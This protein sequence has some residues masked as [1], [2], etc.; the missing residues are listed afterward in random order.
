MKT[1]KIINVKISDKIQKILD[2]ISVQERTHEQLK[3]MYNNISSSTE[4]N[5]YEKEALIEVVTKKIRIDFPAKAKK[6]LGLLLKNY[7]KLMISL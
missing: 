4:V 7:K 1:S 6:M 2:N 3:N 5:D